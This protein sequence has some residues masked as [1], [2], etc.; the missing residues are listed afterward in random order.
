VLGA[1]LLEAIS[2]GSTP[3]EELFQKFG[4]KKKLSLDQLYDAV[5]FLWLADLVQ[6][7]GGILSLNNA[8]QKAIH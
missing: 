1:N 2:E 3:L 5:L 4:S 7:E 6:M 8:S